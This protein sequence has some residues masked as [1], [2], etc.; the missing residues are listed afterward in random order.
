MGRQETKDDSQRPAPVSV[1]PS[2][3]QKSNTDAGSAPEALGAW[4]TKFTAR[5]TSNHANKRTQ[6]VPATP[7]HAE[8]KPTPKADNS[9][10]PPA[11]KPKKNNNN[12]ND[13]HPKGKGKKPKLNSISMG[14]LVPTIKKILP[15]ESKKQG[16]TVSPNDGHP[17]EQSKRESYGGTMTVNQS[18]F[19]A[20]PTSSQWPSLAAAK[21]T[22]QQQQQQQQKRQPPKTQS[23]K[24]PEKS[25][26][27]DNNNQHKS[28][29]LEK[30]SKKNP[31][32]ADGVKWAFGNGRGEN[33]AVGDENHRGA[34]LMIP[35]ADRNRL[36]LQS[37]PGNGKH[38]TEHDFMRLM[39]ANG[40]QLLRKGRQRLKPRKK[41]FT[42]LKKKILTERVRVW[43][44][45][46]PSEDKGD[47][48][49][50]DVDK[51]CTICVYGFTSLEEVEDDDEYE[52]T[53]ENLRDMADK[54]GTVKNIFIPREAAHGHAN[55]ESEDAKHPSFLQFASA[56]E[57]KSAKG[58]WDELVIGGQ[59]LEV[60]PVLVTL[61]GISDEWALTN[62]E[63]Q[64]GCILAEKGRKGGDGHL[65]NPGTTSIVLR[66]VLTE[67]DLGD[68]ECYDESIRDIKDMVERFGTV[69][70]VETNKEEGSPDVIVVYK[71][72][73]EIAKKAVGELQKLTLGGVPISAHL[74]ASD[75][76]VA[77]QPP[78]AKIRLED[79][80]SQDDLEDEECLRESLQDLQQMIEKHGNV[81]SLD[82]TPDNQVLV[83]FQGMDTQKLQ[84]VVSQLDGLCLG[85][86][87]I[88]V[89][90]VVESSN[91]L[92][93]ANTAATVMLQ[94]VLTEDDLEDE[95]CLVESL[96]DL[97]EL[98]RRFG[99]VK[100]IDI[101][102]SDDNKTGVIK[103]SYSNL[104][105]AKAAEKGFDGMIIGGETVSATL[106]AGSDRG[107]SNVESSYH[108][109]PSVAQSDDGLSGK[110]SDGNS[111]PMYS[112]DKLIPERFA[113][114]KRVP[115]VP[116]KPRNY[117]ILTN[118]DEVKTLLVE[119][120]SELMRL[121]LRALHEGTKNAKAR[122][123]VV[124]G[125]RE[126]A[127]GIRANKVKM[128]VMANNLDEYGAI[129]DKLQEILDLAV[130]KDIP[131]LFEL[132]KRVLGKAVG[133]KIKVSVVGVQNT[134]GAHRQF[135]KLVSLAPKLEKHAVEKED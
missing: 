66:S 73:L 65:D 63:W 86:Q 9:S 132:S 16:N 11:K 32:Q 78:V 93:G 74:M 14:D 26:V 71:E 97:R 15:K 121:Q 51:S 112:G 81:S 55:D 127:R 52:E 4:N 19:P 40:G 34:Q 104:S 92:S 109:N 110:D 87:I 31:Q 35:G 12:N 8:S 41:K 61:D 49:D 44:E 3:I 88:K 39:Q 85:G 10:G 106:E 107:M 108:S 99:G 129:D 62:E 115:K 64:K 72:N 105:E 42:A 75:T 24:L 83:S 116:S 94:N 82:I 20:L 1:T 111:K 117:A 38:G 125:L 6:N 68:D 36:Q 98:A 102:R 45:L 101:E 27:K 114:M 128:V 50:S 46:H 69:D 5:R 23:P 7:P 53:L 60:V 33:I 21:A 119:M 118:N 123:R 43:K 59:P 18:D 2:S 70:A 76:S 103:V 28:S 47:E 22:P 122:R 77:S 56:S 89:A 54:V 95:D 100:A 48:T 124:A 57:A 79:V 126:V 13:T 113:A 30:K 91:S 135:V 133:K 134:D 120:L 131:I 84:T 29:A 130:E 58:C 80:L 67:E 37:H 25:K 90:P 96:D 17:P